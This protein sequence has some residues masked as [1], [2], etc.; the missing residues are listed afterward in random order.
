MPKTVGD[1]THVVETGLTKANRDIV[2]ALKESGDEEIIVGDQHYL[3][4]NKFWDK[5]LQK[6]LAQVISVKVWGLAIL[7]VLIFM[8]L[9]TGSEFII[10]FS[11]I[12]GAKGG[13]DIVMKWM[14]T[15]PDNE[16][17]DKV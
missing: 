5:F 4:K 17:I 14:E 13:K 2:S 6:F 8:N 10:G 11:L 9:L 12:I 7:T 16:M 3:S 15:K 1:L